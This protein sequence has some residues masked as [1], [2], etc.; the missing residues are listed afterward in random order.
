MDNFFNLSRVGRLLPADIIQEEEEV[1]ESEW[2]T[3]Q[4]SFISKALCFLR[5]TDGGRGEK[6]SFFTVWIT[7]E[8]KGWL[9]LMHFWEKKVK[10]MTTFGFFFRRQLQSQ[11]A[12]V[13]ELI[14]TVCDP[15]DTFSIL[16]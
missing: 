1:C 7:S 8:E 2:L 10:L 14:S 16:S 11:I 5:S 3:L 4:L 15:A 9:S 12:L 6:E 13:K